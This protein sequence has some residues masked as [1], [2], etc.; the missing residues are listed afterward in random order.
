[1]WQGEIFVWFP[2]R[3]QNRCH[4][5][6]I[7]LVRLYFGVFR[8]GLKSD[9]SD[10][11]HCDTNVVTLLCWPVAGCAR[12]RPGF[13]YIFHIK[14]LTGAKCRCRS[15]FKSWRNLDDHAKYRHHH[16]LLVTLNHWIMWRTI[17]LVPERRGCSIG[18]S[19][20]N[21]QNGSVHLVYI[22]NIRCEN[23]GPAHSQM[24]RTRYQII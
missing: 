21:T 9:R 11:F 16:P 3:V 14:D 18:C 23:V 19:P 6:N 17:R 15:W 1:M 12:F 7:C 5:I 2:L 10:H 13:F 20:T 8:A 22:S 4:V 24:V